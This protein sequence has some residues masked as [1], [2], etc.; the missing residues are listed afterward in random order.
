MA[1]RAA[2][3]AT[4][5]FSDIEGSTQLLRRLAGKYGRVHDQHDRLLRASF[6]AHRGTEM[7]TEGDSFFVVFASA[8]EAVAAA[9]DAQLAL[10]R[11]HWPDGASLRVRMGVH[12]GEATPSG[13]TYIGLDIHRAARIAAAAHGGQVVISD[14]TRALLSGV[15]PE[16]VG[17]LDLGEQ[18]LRDLEAPERLFQLVIPGLRRDFPPLRSLGGHHTNL[19]AQITSFIGREQ[20]LA[21]VRERLSA[22]RLV[23]LVG[24]GGTGKT[25]LMIQVAMELIDR[26]RDGAWLVELAPISDPAL[27]VGEVARTLGIQEQ[28]GR[29]PPEAVVDFLRSKELLLLLDNCEHLIAS[30]ADLVQAL[31]ASCPDLTVLASS[32]E[33]LGVSGETVFPVPSL[34]L[35]AP[36]DLDADHRAT[37][38]GQVEAITRS[39]AVRL[40]VDRASATLPGFAL[41]PGN[42]AAVGEI[43][44]RLDGIPLALELA[45]ARV[46]VLSVQEIAQ[47]LGDRFRLL[48]GGRRTAVPRQ[49]TLQALIDWSWSLLTE[50]D[51]LLLRRLSVFAGG[52]TLE[53]AAAVTT[54]PADASNATGDDVLLDAL[55]GLSRLVDR[56]LVV[57]DHGPSTRYHMLETIRQY[58]RDRLME[59]GEAEALRRRHLAFYRA[60][61]LEAEPALLGPE[62]VAWL[63]RIDAD[64]DNLRSALE[65]AF[66]A[67]PEAALEL[68]VS[69]IAYCRSRS[70][71]SEIVDRLGQAVA[72]GHALWPSGEVRT[73]DQSVLLAR[74]L[75]GAAFSWATWASGH[76]AREWAEQA[77]AIAREAGDPGA[78]ADALTSALQASVLAGLS[79]GVRDWTS[80]LLQL[81][82]ERGD[83]YRLSYVEAGLA[84]GV[85]PGEAGLAE[86][87]V[88]RATDAARRS[89]GPA[90]I[91]F[92]A[93]TR[94]RVASYAGGIADARPWF[95]EA[96]ASY[97]NIGDRRMELVARSDLA[98]ALRRS[99]S[100]DEAEDMYR[101]TIHEWQHVGNRGAIANQLEAF[102]LVARARRDG[103]RA[104]RLLGAAEVLREVAEAP[105]M[106]IERDEYDRQ[107]ARLRD[108]LDGPTLESAWAEG[109]HLT[110][111]A[112]VA[113]ALSG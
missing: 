48:T 19:S 59:S 72:V 101:Q 60:L 37:D 108:E 55:E 10:D 47:R 105:M 5:L 13:D 103:P 83:W 53:A 14:A 3:T 65:W 66:E 15:A 2:R 34:S 35:P 62:M 74:V 50:P 75:A 78:L 27:V 11:A 88:T 21:E 7:G 30:A 81:C 96:M 57:A 87:H 77:V 92:A 84:M 71:G 79:V 61:A 43:C 93:L 12:S 104:A 31:L 39:E 20:E 24:V 6:S 49:Q 63:A 52:W 68:S 76:E 16:G 70:V 106:A 56:S 89:G 91:A 95:L 41:E 58:A 113:Y 23:T 36:I 18:R 17:I 32:R 22:G 42:L 100:I 29:P 67:E 85:A 33:A 102:A 97:G 54:G 110:A 9:V 82:E 1:P 44:R 38:P 28:P 111:D 45:A 109:R 73:R 25:R 4:F 40:F 46:T 26:Y 64:A 51:R 94:G 99:G 80:E 90:V 112:A 8:R 107:V 69:M 86:V 98:H